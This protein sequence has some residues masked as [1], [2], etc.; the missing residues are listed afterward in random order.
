MKQLENIYNEFCHV[1]AE[2]VKLCGFV[3][4]MKFVV[5]VT[6]QSTSSTEA[7]FFEPSISHQSGMRV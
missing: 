6:N 5:I 2:N 3:A 7:A 1:P 4:S